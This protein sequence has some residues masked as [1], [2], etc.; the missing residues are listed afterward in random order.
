MDLFTAVI[1]GVLQGIFE[2]L[3]ISSQGNIMAYLLALFESSPEE[4]LKIAVLLHT[5]T[6]LAA[7]VYFRKE[8][9]QILECKTKADKELAR[10]ILFATLATAITAV[11]LYFALKQFLALGV[12]YVILAIAVLLAATGLLQLKR[13][14]GKKM[15]LTDR[16]ALLAGLAQGLSVLPGISRS[17]V[18]TSALL[19]TDANPEQAFRLSFI[20]SI[21]AVLVAELA[22]GLAEGVYLEGFAAVSIIIAFIMGLASMDILI[23]AARRINFSYFCFALAALYLAVF[24]VMALV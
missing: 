5:G 23:R 19:F 4:A 6:L 17:G 9:G 2:W 24:A 7:I 12:A 11:P 21:P 20:M 15:R 10:F 16:N 8:L 14:V 13:K 1:T 22:F 3:P 18:T